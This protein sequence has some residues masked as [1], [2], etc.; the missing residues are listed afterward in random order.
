MRK[1]KKY[2]GRKILVKID[3]GNP[4]TDFEKKINIVRSLEDF[5]NDVENEMYTSIELLQD[6]LTLYKCESKHTSDLSELVNIRD[7]WKAGI[8]KY[9]IFLTKEEIMDYL[10]K[11]YLVAVAGLQEVDVLDVENL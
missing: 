8:Y 5:K 7:R 4:E 1:V 6:N 9:D 10:R 2:I 3:T 11:E